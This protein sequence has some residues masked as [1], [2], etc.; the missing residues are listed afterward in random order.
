MQ[1][2]MPLELQRPT[3]ASYLCLEDLTWPNSQAPLP[4]KE[5]SAAKYAQS[6]VV[7]QTTPSS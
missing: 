3:H 4:F 2:E 1:L 6:S 5:V 7:V